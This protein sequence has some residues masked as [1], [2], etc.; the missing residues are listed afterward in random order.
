MNVFNMLYYFF[1]VATLCF[2]S[3]TVTVLASSAK[4]GKAGGDDDLVD[5]AF[6]YVLREALLPEGGVR[7][8]L[9][10]Q[11]LGST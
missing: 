1:Y 9:V 7:L 8:V 6:G 11:P 10:S 4:A 3:Q 5:E 2:M